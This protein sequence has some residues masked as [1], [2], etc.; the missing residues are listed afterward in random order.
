MTAIR[1]TERSIATSVLTNLQGNIRRISET[2]QQLSSGKLVSKASDSPGGAVA[3]MQ[4]RS[5]MGRQQQHS[6][7]ADDGL[8]WLTVADS[9]LATVVGQVNR[10]RDLTLQAMNTGSYGP[11]A[12]EAIVLEVVDIRRSLIGLANA[13]YLDRP[14]FGGTTT[15]P[16][17]FAADGSYAGDAGSVIRAIADNTQVRVDVGGEETFGSGADQLFSVLDDLVVAIRSNPGTIST[18]LTAIDQAST[19]LRSAQ[20]TIGA[21]YNQVEKARQ[22]ADDRLIDLQTQLSNVEDID[23]PKTITDLQLRQT[24]YE[25]ALAAAAKV[26]QPSLVDFLR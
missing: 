23:L 1:V 6:R 21:R 22:A 17:A 4:V 11:D 8:G 25:A 19:R 15:G 14:V 26:V 13:T 2:Q 7:N 12:G 5:E 18:S 3:A 9:T 20:S 10:V 24:A 16:V